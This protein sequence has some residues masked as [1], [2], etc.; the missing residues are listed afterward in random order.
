[1]INQVSKHQLC[2]L[3]SVILKERKAL[4]R[5]VD[6]YTKKQDSLN[7]QLSSMQYQADMMMILMRDLMNHAQMNTNT[8]T[9]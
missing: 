9:L 8:F 2:K 5:L 3:I 1:M 6:N 7:R 4:I